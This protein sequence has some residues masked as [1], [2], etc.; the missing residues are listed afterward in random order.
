MASD[1][2]AFNV[3]IFSEPFVDIRLVSSMTNDDEDRFGAVVLKA[4]SD[5]LAKTPVAYSVRIV[6]ATGKV[7]QHTNPRHDAAPAP[8]PSGRTARDRDVS[9][10]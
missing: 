8:A 3:S 6:T 7:F 1:P 10:P 5:L 2:S 9:H 4:V